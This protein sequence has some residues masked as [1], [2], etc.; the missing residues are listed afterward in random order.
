M[1]RVVAPEA[2]EEEAE[3]VAQALAAQPKEALR[4]TKK[5][6]RGP[7][8]EAT[9][10]AFQREGAIFVERLGSPEAMEAFMAF[11]ARK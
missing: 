1:N 9:L 4:L 11:A 8:R 6:I 2:L 5:L 3:K 10:A 7:L